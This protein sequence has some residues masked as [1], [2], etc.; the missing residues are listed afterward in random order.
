M[1]FNGQWS[2]GGSFGSSIA[3]ADK[4]TS[5]APSL[6]V[7]STI[8]SPYALFL[9]KLHNGL[10]E[11]REL[12]DVRSQMLS[13]LSRALIYMIYQLYSLEIIAF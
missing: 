6:C 5:L 7:A 1:D 9:I 13:L 11:R 12:S 4:Q 8:Y 10:Y 3:L 2:F